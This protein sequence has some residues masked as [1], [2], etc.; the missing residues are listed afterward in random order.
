MTVASWVR[1]CAG[2]AVVVL[3]LA[4]CGSSP[5]ATGA[6][7][8]V[9]DAGAPAGVGIP[10]T[11]PG[12]PTNVTAT[13]AGGGQ[14]TVSWTA[15]ASDGGSA[16][17]GYTVIDSWG[18]WETASVATTV[19][20]YD[21]TNGIP[22]SFTV[23][24]TNAVGTSPFSNPSNAV[25]PRTVPG[26]PTDLGTSP[27]DAQ[28]VVRWLIPSSDGGS[29][30]TGYTV[31]SSPGGQTAWT[32]ATGTQ[33]TVFGLTN[34]TSYTFTVTATNAF[35]TSPASAPS[36]AD[37][38]Y[39]VPGAPTSVSATPG[40]T[41]ASVSW[42]VPASDGSSAI[43]LYMV[44]AS[45]GGQVTSTAGTTATVT[46]LT[47]GTAYTFTVSAHNRAGFSTPSTPSTAVTPT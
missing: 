28:M 11:V 16:I 27:G 26:A 42:T 20:V 43:N 6:L 23:T 35:G 1:A 3:S 4:A 32:P 24:A 14:A 18:G 37:A 21:L 5:S 45:P 41:Q 34:G 2:T 31:T 7:S 10:D 15:P 8:N 9:S 25:T 44:I 30:I 33:A 39:T 22:V 38:P 12:S 13:T 36:A 29:A 17:T 46:G 19:T 47:N 40:N